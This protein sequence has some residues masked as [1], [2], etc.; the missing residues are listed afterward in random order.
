MAT[1]KQ[2]DAN[3]LNAQIS[4]GPRT[5]EGKRV[6]SQNA[7]KSGLDAES[8]FVL[9]ESQD[10]FAQLQAEYFDRFAP[11]T[12]EQ[13]FQ[14]DNL[15]R[16]EWLLRRYHRV[17]SHLWE[18]QISLCDR[19]TGFR[20]GEAYAKASNIF[21]RLRRTIVAV[22]KA[23]TEAMQELTRL[24]QASEPVPTADSVSQLASFLNSGSDALSDFAMAQMERAFRDG[25]AASPPPQA[26]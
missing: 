20:L 21:M 1:Q 25:G 13:R 26:G 8:Q 18:Y 23:Y 19:S 4:T 5:E 3:R 16:N 15:I 12:P 9:G 11:A 6:S 17:E 24:Q 22:E 10:E 14:V 7:L 2:I